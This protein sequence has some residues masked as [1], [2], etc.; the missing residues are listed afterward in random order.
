[1]NHENYLLMPSLE[2]CILEVTEIRILDET[3]WDCFS[4]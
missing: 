2:H 1:M 3:L 4:Y